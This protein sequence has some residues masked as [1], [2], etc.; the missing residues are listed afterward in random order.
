MAI[1]YRSLSF[2]EQ[3][4][5]FQKKLN[6]PTETFEDVWGEA[7]NKAFMVAGAAKADVLEAFRKAVD[8]AIVTG[9]TL[10]QFSDSFDDIVARYG[11]EYYGTAGWRSWI[12]YD[13][14][15][16]QSYHAGRER[17]MADPELRKRRPY[18]LYKHGNSREPRVE[19]L[20]WD[21]KVVPLDDAW[22]D[23]HT[24]QN[25]YGCSCRK[26]MLSERDVKERGLKVES[27]NDMPFPNEGIDQGFDY[28]PGEGDTDRLRETLQDKTKSYEPK[29]KKYV[30]TTL[31][32]SALI[33]TMAKIGYFS[34]NRNRILPSS[35]LESLSPLLG[36]NGINITDLPINDSTW[37]Q[38]ANLTPLQPFS[39]FADMKGLNVADLN[40]SANDD[41]WRLVASAFAEKLTV[42][43]LMT[44]L[45][46]DNDGNNS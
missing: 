4:E 32:M 9:L 41:T 2:D 34:L 35:R 27:G 11:W 37:Q 39:P 24:P 46:E 19:H 22:W 40:L 26:F 8:E 28:R 12:I 6:L 25:G 1:D 5:Y 23:T 31:S 14:N 10:E 30:L 45:F 33:G 18:G 38:V 21:G 15:L 13:T 43:D 44:L 7:H 29:L 20:A 42:D 36:M 17:Q 3:I 16:R